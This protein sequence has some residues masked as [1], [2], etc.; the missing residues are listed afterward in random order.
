LNTIYVDS[1]FELAKYCFQIVINKKKFKKNKLCGKWI[2]N[3]NN[4]IN[5]KHKRFR[6]NFELNND[7]LKMIEMHPNWLPQKIAL[8]F[9][10]MYPNL[11]IISSQVKRHLKYL[12]F[13]QNKIDPREYLN[14]INNS[15]K[16]TNDFKFLFFLKNDFLICVVQNNDDF[17]FP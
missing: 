11:N 13:K 10:K 16:Y 14:N 9:I 4:E 6:W 3:N 2:N 7:L 8:T 17:F 12:K 5:F 1:H 15:L